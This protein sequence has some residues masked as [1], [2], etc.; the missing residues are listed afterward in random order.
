MDIRDFV[1]LASYP[2]SGN[3]YLRTILWHAFGLRSASIYP[4][5]LG[6]NK[7]LEEYVGH[8]EHNPKLKE[9]LQETGVPL[10]KTHEHANDNRP[11]IYIIRDGRAACVSLWEFYNRNLSIEAVI[12]GQH[13]FG[14]WADHV[15]SW[16]PWKRPNTLL[17]EYE[18]LRDDLPAALNTISDFL[19]V[20][21]RTTHIPNRD[22]IA[23]VDGKWV[24]KKTNWRAHLRGS[25]LKRFVEINRDI[26]RKTGHL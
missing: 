7:V 15:K 11:A 25:K 1:W 18:Q 9:Q 13:H 8:L 12:E 5:D 26:L 23:S 6:G 24:K 16:D 17:L 2:R 4:N 22:T 19:D 3:T 21:I 14:T 10:I 20:E